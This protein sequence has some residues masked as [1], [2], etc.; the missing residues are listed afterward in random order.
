MWGLRG[1][2]SVQEV[3]EFLKRNESTVLFHLALAS[4]VVS[5][6]RNISL[7]TEKMLMS[8]KGSNIVKN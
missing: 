2:I 6:K 4:D 3:I 7:G 8:N 1:Y 5:P